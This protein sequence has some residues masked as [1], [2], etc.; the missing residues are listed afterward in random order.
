MKRSILLVLVCSLALVMVSCDGSG[1]GSYTGIYTVDML[2]GTW[3]YNAV[4]SADS[5]TGQLVIAADGSLLLFTNSLCANQNAK[6]TFKVYENGFVKGRQYGWC[7]NGTM[8]LKFAM[9]FV[10]STRKIY[11]IVDLHWS[12][13]KW[14]RYTI[15]MTK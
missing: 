14:R 4:S 12:G 1:G 6:C 10:N 13:T 8:Y 2:E 9:D 11:G 15:T 7:G 3:D 5:F